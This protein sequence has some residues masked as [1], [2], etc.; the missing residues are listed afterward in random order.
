MKLRVTI[1]TPTSTVWISQE[2]RHAQWSRNGTLLSKLSFKLKPPM[3]SS[4][5]FS[6]SLSPRELRDKSRLPAMPRTVT[7]NSSDKR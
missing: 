6:A 5:D 7:K 3:V 2:I 4:S 1:A